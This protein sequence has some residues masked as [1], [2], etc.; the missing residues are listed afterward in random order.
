MRVSWEN[1][2]SILLYAEEK[3]CPIDYF[4][5]CLLD[6]FVIYD[7]KCINVD[8]A[9]PREFII[10]REVYLNEWSSE[11]EVIMTDDE[12]KVEDFI[13]QFEQEE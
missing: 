10:L 11:I 6:N 12:K 13:S 2:Q 7:A 1:A 9:E 8:N 5:G 4:E 3:G